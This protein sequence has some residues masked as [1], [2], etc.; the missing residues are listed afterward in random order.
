MGNISN[1][2]SSPHPVTYAISTD[3]LCRSQHCF[4]IK[5]YR[6]NLWWYMYVFLS[7]RMNQTSHVGFWSLL[8]RTGNRKRSSGLPVQSVWECAHAAV[9]SRLQKAS[10]VSR[11]Y[12]DVYG[13]G[14]DGEIAKIMFVFS[15]LM[16]VWWGAVTPSSRKLPC[17]SEWQYMT[18]TCPVTGTVL[19]WSRHD[20]S[21]SLSFNPLRLGLDLI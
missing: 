10:P 8:F 3:T 12:W 14:N 20:D 6:I 15:L 11:H 1:P 2:A 13:L 17:S 19:Y 7:T 18:L 4:V 16:Q 21:V 9:C 5:M